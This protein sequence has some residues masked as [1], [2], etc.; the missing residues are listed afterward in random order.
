M[1]GSSYALTSGRFVSRSGWKLV[2]SRASI[3]RPSPG[4]RWARADRARRRRRSASGWPRADPRRARRASRGPRARRAGWARAGWRRGREAAAGSVTA[5]ARSGSQRSAR[6]TGQRSGTTEPSARP[7][8]GA[9]P[10]ARL[11]EVDA[12]AQR[13]AR[14][15]PDGARAL[16]PPS[17]PGSTCTASPSSASS[18]RPRRRGRRAGPVAT[19]SWAAGG[20]PPTA[21]PGGG[22]ADGLDDAAADAAAPAT[23][24]MLAKSPFL[25]ASPRCPSPR[26]SRTSLPSPRTH[27]ATW[28]FPRLSP[29][30]ERPMNESQLRA[31]LASVSPALRARLDAAG[32]D[33]DRLV[34]A[35]RAALGAGARRAATAIGTRATGCAAVVEAP[36]EGDVRDAPAPGTPEHER[37]AAIGLEAI[38]AGGAGALR[39]GGGHGDAHG[40]RRQGAR[41]GVR[42][43]HVPRSAAARERVVVEAR[44]TDGPALAHDERRHRRRPSARPWRRPGRAPHV[45]T[46][47]AGPRAPPHARGRALPSTTT[48]S[49]ARTPPATATCRTP[50]GARASSRPSSPRG[51]KYVWIANLDNLGA[52][53]DPAL[54]GHFIET[55]RRRHGRG[56][57]QGRGRQGR[58]P[59]L[60]RRRRT[61]EGR[62]DAAPPGARGVPPAEGLRRG[63][64][65]RLQHE[66]VPRAGRG[67]A[68]TRT[69]AG[70]GSRSRRRWA[71]GRRCSSSACSRS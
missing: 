41:R 43:A 32:F 19:R 6:R 31:D 66:H 46:L 63:R 22:G 49:P 48:G 60:G 20:G 37:L 54:L 59:R 71:S 70:T 14:R 36:R 3:R 17:G 45:A 15:A 53:I 12:L 58:H 47:H 4:S 26:P 56:G 62:V 61:T 65:A 8:G 13:V 21:T 28:R 11:V 39:D 9:R 25:I 42:R 44:R 30:R 5:S 40:R 69:S 10:A 7:G 35:R 33:A 51:G 64:R 38:E 57:A 16:R 23:T 50:S 68:R 29:H 27:D 1:K 18:R 24:A 34:V 2:R 52:T 67:A 55:R